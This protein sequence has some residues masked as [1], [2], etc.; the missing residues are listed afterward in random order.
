MDGKD[1][2]SGGRWMEASGMRMRRL[3]TKRGRR[4]GGDLA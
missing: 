3:G 4:G 2:R 1:F